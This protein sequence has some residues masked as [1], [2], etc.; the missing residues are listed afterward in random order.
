MRG[1]S[2]AV[3]L[4]MIAAGG[5]VLSGCGSVD[6]GARVSTGGDNLVVG[7]CIPGTYDAVYGTRI[8]LFDNDSCCTVYGLETGLMCEDSIQGLQIGAL[9]SSAD[10]GN[11]LQISVN[12]KA[13][14][15][16][17]FQIGVWNTVDNG[18]MFQIG[19]L[20][21]AG[22]AD[23][24]Q[25]GLLN[26]SPNSWVKFMPFINV[27]VCGDAPTPAAQVNDA[28]N[29]KMV[30]ARAKLAEK[31]AEAQAKAEKYEAKAAAAQAKAAQCEAEAAA[32]QAAAVAR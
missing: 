24:V 6:V 4:A 31:A 17:M 10:S 13:G 19:L 20:N 1:K 15:G 26:E 21:K 12:N 9:R 11:G 18:G 2:L 5:L 16:N 25:I 32:I 8:V 7:A 23:G 28:M 3:K 22:Y 27:A 29:S 30:K 14:S